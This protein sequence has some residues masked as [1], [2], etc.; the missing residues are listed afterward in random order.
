MAQLLLAVPQLAPVPPPTVAPPPDEGGPMGGVPVAVRIP[1]HELLPALV[2]LQDRQG[3][4]ALHLAAR[5][6]NPDVVAT[7][8]A[9]AEGARDA[10]S[11]T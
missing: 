9:G 7:L 4:T 2:E 10:G 1:S 8:L 11:I 6:G 5:G 3:C